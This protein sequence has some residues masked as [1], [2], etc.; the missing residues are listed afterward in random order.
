MGWTHKTPNHKCNVLG[1]FCYL[2]IAGRCLAVSSFCV[3]LRQPAADCSL[4]RK[5]VEWFQCS[6]RALKRPSVPTRQTI[7]SKT[8]N[9]PMIMRREVWKSCS[10]PQVGCSA[11]RMSH[12]RLCSLSHSVAYIPKPGRSPNTS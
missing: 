11:F 3:K 1:G 4:T 9:S 12:T 2:W 6:H 5:M 8:A 10:S 7:P